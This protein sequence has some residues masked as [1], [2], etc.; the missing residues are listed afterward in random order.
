[1]KDDDDVIDL[2]RYL[3]RDTLAREA[4]TKRASFSV[5]GGNGDR[6]RFALPIWRSIDLVGARRGALVSVPE[7][8]ATDPRAEF[9]LDLGSD[10]ARTE[11]SLPGG[12]AADSFDPP[13]VFESA[14]GV[15]VLLGM[16]ITIPCL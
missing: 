4:G 3:D 6:S 12:A 11:F 14:E 8:A 10:P 15:A 7:G 16:H 1:M 9:V 2:T 5:F 13:S